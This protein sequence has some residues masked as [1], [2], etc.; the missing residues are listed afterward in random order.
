MCGID[1]TPLPGQSAPV[2]RRS[3]LLDGVVC[4]VG[5]SGRAR[6]VGDGIPIA[7]DV[8]DVGAINGDVIACVSDCEAGAVS[9][10]GNCVL[11]AGERQV[12]VIACDGFGVEVAADAEV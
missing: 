11:E 4:G 12:A 6:V 1:G 7:R 9:G 10:G 5:D 3:A 2:L 8:G